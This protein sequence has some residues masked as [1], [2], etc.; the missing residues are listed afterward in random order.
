MQFGDVVIINNDVPKMHWELAV[1]EKLIT[2]L[3]GV[4]IAVEIATANGWTN[5]PIS[6]MLPL[7]VNKDDSSTEI[8][9]VPPSDANG[10][11]QVGLLEMLL[12]P[13]VGVANLLHAA[14]EDIAN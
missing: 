1:V 4:T 14:P 7:E 6:R 2:G 3:D 5:R 10:D 8:Q 12:L 9:Q 11:V 13:Q